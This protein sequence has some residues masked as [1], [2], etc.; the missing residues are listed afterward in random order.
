MC[1]N[2][3]II[4]KVLNR[5]FIKEGYYADLVLV[6]PNLAETVDKENIL[7]KCGWSPFDG[8]TFR[9][10]VTHTIV[11]GNLVYENG[12]FN[13]EVKGSRLLFEPDSH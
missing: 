8:S 1:H 2:P 13:E 5:G 7:A 4:F 10:S 11:S 12:D 9:S 3:S 6:D